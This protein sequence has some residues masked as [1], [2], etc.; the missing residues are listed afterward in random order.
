MEKPKWNYE[1]CTISKDNCPW[2]QLYSASFQ[3]S[4][5]KREEPGNN[6]GQDFAFIQSTISQTSSRIHNDVLFYF[7]PGWQSITTDFFTKHV[8]DFCPLK[9]KITQCPGGFCLKIHV[10]GKWQTSDSSWEFL[11]IENE[12]IETA[13]NNNKFS[14]PT[15][16]ICFNVVHICPSVPPFVCVICFLC[17]SCFDKLFLCFT[18][19]GGSSSLFKF[20]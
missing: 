11:K 3:G 16:V 17:F 9:I 15:I 13:Q 18:Q 10:Y 5:Y 20:W 6:F 19:F 4:T 1:L 2:C 14:K 7:C 8:Q 12:Q